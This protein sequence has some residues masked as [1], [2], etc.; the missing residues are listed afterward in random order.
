[1]PTDNLLTT[2]SVLEHIRSEAIH[3]VRV[4]FTD[5]HG[6]LRGKAIAASTMA[7]VFEN[8][9]GVP[10]SLLHKDLRG[11]H[12]IGLWEPTG[13]RQLDELVGARNIVLRPDPNTFRPIP[14]MEP[15]TAVVLSDLETT[16]GAPIELSTRQIYRKALS[17]LDSQHRFRAGLELEFHLFRCDDSGELHN[18][19]Q[20]WDLLGEEGLD[21]LQPILEA[22]RRCLSELGMPPATI[23]IEHGPSQVELT[24]E[25]AIGLEIAD[26]AV[27]VRTAIRHTARRHG[28]QATF[29]SRPSIGGD[30]FPSGWHVHQSLVSDSNLDSLFVPPDSEQL[31][32]P[33][34]EHFVAGILRNASAACLLTTP[35]VTG[36]KRYRP[37]AVT[38]DRITWSNEHRGAMIRVVGGTGD[39]STR[40]ENR[41]GDPAANPYLLLASQVI[42]GID[43]LTNQLVP[44]PPTD[45]PYAT[46]AGVA[47]PRTLGEAVTEFDQSDVFQAAL[48]GDVVDYLVALKRAEWHR[49]SQA[50]TDWEQREYFDRF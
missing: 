44:P 38:P 6:L 27:L 8:G 31:L 1:M 23:E 28:H 16:S 13:H 40:I 35:T 9:I 18:S 7:T 11:N 14:W 17:S 42:S 32:S 41:A 5:Q 26:Q 30:N 15:G 36:Y 2:D 33:I 12:V 46:N 24:F 10:G 45:S 34:G 48:G 50:V 49:F 20:G 47:L 29:M 25:P 19:H 3:T 43:G 22:L 21:R 37:N 4:L 39:P